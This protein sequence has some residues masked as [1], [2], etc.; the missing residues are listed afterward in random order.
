MDAD[1]ML[2]G[3]T[4]KALEDPGEL[5]EL[6]LESLAWWLMSEV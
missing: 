1:G 3:A 4:D 6:E 5:V 2:K